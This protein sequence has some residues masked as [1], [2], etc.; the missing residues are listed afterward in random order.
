MVLVCDSTSYVVS[1]TVS[2]L[3]IFVY[4]YACVV[5]CYRTAVLNNSEAPQV[6][7][8]LS[9]YKIS[10]INASGSLG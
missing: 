6:K 9:Y 4:Y 1:G 2:G 5:K 7:G 8:K 10:L 3:T